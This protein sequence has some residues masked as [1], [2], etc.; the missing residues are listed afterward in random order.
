MGRS[1]P[2]KKAIPGLWG[3]LRYFWP[4]IHKQYGLLLISAIAV[5]IKATETRRGCGG[6]GG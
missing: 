2:Q 3:V 1:K 5:I 6:D 4:Y